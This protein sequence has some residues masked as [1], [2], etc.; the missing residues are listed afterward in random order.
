MNKLSS[1]LHICPKFNASGVTVSRLLVFFL[2]AALTLFANTATAG[3][4]LRHSGNFG[5]GF[6]G[7][8][9]SGASFGGGLS[10]KY[11][12]SDTSAVQATISGTGSGFNV[13]YN[14][15]S[16]AIS[17][18]YLIEMPII[19]SKDEL[20]LAWNAGPGVGVSQWSYGNYRATTLGVSGVVGLEIN[21]KVIPIDIVVEYRPLIL[22]GESYSWMGTSSN[23]LI[24]VNTSS[25]IRYY[26]K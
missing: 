17:A 11:W 4:S 6:G 1:A 9:F 21:L 8:S 15:S 20:E 22:L 2:S 18:D 25:H 19:T 7:G 12:L 23:N 16:S 24:L 3:D 5:L 13:G 14:T 26:F 10:G